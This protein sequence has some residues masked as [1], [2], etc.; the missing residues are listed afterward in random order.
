MNTSL[1]MKGKKADLRNALANLKAASNEKDEEIIAEY[2][3]AA[4]NN[5][6]RILGK[7]DVE[8]VLGQYIFKLLHWKIMFHVKHRFARNKKVFSFTL[9]LFQCF[10]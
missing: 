7:I 9:R 1:R 8:E 5:L 3:R 6:K 10:T 4:T 2:L